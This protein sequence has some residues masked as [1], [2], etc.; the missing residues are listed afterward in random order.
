MHVYFVRHTVELRGEFFDRGLQ[1]QNIR[2]SPF[3][4]LPM[5]SFRDLPQGTG[6]GVDPNVEAPGIPASAL[7]YKAPVA[8]PEID[9]HTSAGREQ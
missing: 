7:V 3:G 2:D 4:M 6:A 5:D 8:C 1:E 9:D